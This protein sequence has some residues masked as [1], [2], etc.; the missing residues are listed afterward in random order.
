MSEIK[1]LEMHSSVEGADEHLGAFLAYV[2]SNANGIH[3]GE[4]VRTDALEVD[5]DFFVELVFGQFF[6]TDRFRTMNMWAAVH[7][8]QIV[9]AF[10]GQI[11]SGFDTREISVYMLSLDTRPGVVHDHDRI[12]QALSQIEA[13]GATKGCRWCTCA[14]AIEEAAGGRFQS[15]RARLFERHFDLKPLRLL[16]RKEIRD[17]R[18]QPHHDG[19]SG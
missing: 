2:R 18:P 13:W 7:E 3:R 11:V 10:I 16:L 1:Y 4:Q 6:Q 19:S 8:D 9:G 5:P 12:R 17:D 14:V 15:P